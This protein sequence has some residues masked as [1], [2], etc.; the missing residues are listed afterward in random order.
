MKMIRYA[1]ARLI[2]Y[3][4]QTI[5]YCLFSSFSAFLLIACL[6]LYHLQ[7]ALANQVQDRLSFIGASASTALLPA[8]ELASRFYLKG[9]FSLFFLF[10]FF[11]I[12]FFYYSLRQN[13]QELMNWRLTG[14]SKAKLFL[15]I[16]LVSCSFLSFFVVSWFYCGSSASSRFMKHCFKGSI[17]LS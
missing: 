10:A 7:S 8:L 1:T 14:L 13:Q 4:K 11:F 12:F 15:F 6:T 9:I 16:F 17:F 5:L 2:Y 3:K